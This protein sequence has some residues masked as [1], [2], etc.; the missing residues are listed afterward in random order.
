M[1]SD[2]DFELLSLE[3]APPVRE[4]KLKRLKKALRVSEEPPVHEF[5]SGPVNHSEFEALSLEESNELSRLGLGSEGLGGEGDSNSGFHG[6]GGG[7]GEMNSGSDGLGGGEGEMSSGSDGLGGGG[8]IDSGFDGLG[9]ESEMKSNF[10]GLAG[11]EDGNGAKRV[12]DFD[13][14]EEEFGEEGKDRNWEMPE[15]SGDVRVEETDKK[16]C[17]SDGF[18]EE[19]NKKKSKRAKSEAAAVKGK[20]TT[21]KERQEHLKQLHAESQRLLRETRDAAFKP[22]PLVQKPI[23]SVLEKIRKRKLEVSRKCSN[24][25]DY[26]VLKTATEEPIAS[27]TEKGYSANE[28]CKDGSNDKEKHSS[29]ENVPSGTDVDEE[30]KQTFRAPIDDTQDLFFDS[31][32]TDS[33]D[34][35]P[36]DDPKSPMEEVF[37]PSILAMNLK[38]DSAP[39]D[40]VSSDEEDYNDKENIAPRSPEVAD[41]PSSPIGDPVKAFVDDEAEEEDDSDHDLHRFEDTDEDEDDGDTAELNDMIATGYEERPVDDERR[42]ELHQKWL[43]QQDASGTEKLMQKLKFGSKGK[44][45]ALVEEKDADG[46]EDEEFGDENAE[47]KELGDDDAAEDSAPANAVRMNLREIKQMMPLLYT[48][49]DDAYLSSDDDE[50]EKRLSKQCLS[51]KAEMQATFLSPAED[52]S[53]REVFGHIKK[54]NIASDTKKAKAPSFPNMLLAGGDRSISSKSSFLGRGPSH[55]L[56]SSSKHGLS[57]VRSFILVRGDSNSRSSMSEDSSDTIQKEILPK[58]TT[59]AKLSK[60]KAK[61]G[62]Q[63]S[64]PDMVS[65]EAVANTETLVEAGAQIDRS[66][67]AGAQAEAS[68]EAGMGTNTSAG[69][70]LL[71]VLRQPS[72]S[73]RRGTGEITVD[74]IESVLASLEDGRKSKRA[75]GRVYRRT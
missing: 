32:T 33:K 21:E 74:Q 70:S 18:E 60:S 59:A 69:S 58:K 31:Q 23:S 15:G 50:T 25:G 52:E 5:E 73:S 30:P 66:A 4:T 49:N 71:T 41:V 6:L 63:K 7:E 17:S 29:S 22:I 9:G 35:L 10:D 42:N 24:T 14:V 54:L 8:E 1:D 36:N 56:P 27:Q 65:T 16:R 2:D 47:D 75:N 57:T 28:V 46:Q 34:D 39:P 51:E 20:R 12:L 44:K 19:D 67:G 26:K 45:T 55:S 13:S 53:S 43:E 48:D 61:F 72:L 62:T 40:D 3:A 11:G 37:A 64:S 68:A 38:L